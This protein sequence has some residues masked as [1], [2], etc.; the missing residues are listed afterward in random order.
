MQQKWQNKQKKESISQKRVSGRKVT[1]FSFQ[2]CFVT[3]WFCVQ[4]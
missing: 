3:C 1:L 4:S 2:K